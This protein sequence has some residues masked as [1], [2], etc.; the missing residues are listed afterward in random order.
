MAQ[1]VEVVAIEKRVYR[2]H[3]ISSHVESP[4]IRLSIELELLFSATLADSSRRVVRLPGDD[5]FS[6]TVNELWRYVVKAN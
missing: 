4:L 2:R 6:P 3:A 1:D 5:L